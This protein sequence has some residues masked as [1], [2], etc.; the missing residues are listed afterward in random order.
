VLT[1]FLKMKEMKKA[2]TTMP[3]KNPKVGENI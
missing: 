2:A 1:S 3:Y